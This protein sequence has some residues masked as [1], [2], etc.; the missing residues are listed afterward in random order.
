MDMPIERSWLTTAEA[1]K[2]LGLAQSTLREAA[3]RGRLRVERVSPRLNAIT[4]EELERYR[5]EHL[6]K[7]GWT[8]KKAPG[9]TPDV[10]AAEYAR[11]YRT[12]KKTRGTLDAAKQEERSANE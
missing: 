10:K 5:Q 4:R 11:A 6:G 9:Y 8:K 3:A 1:A 12:R 2:E 7:S